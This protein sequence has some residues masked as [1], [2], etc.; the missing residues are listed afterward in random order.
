[1]ERQNVNSSSLKSI[2]YDL[3]LATLE[4]EF[5]N[6]SIYQYFDIPENIYDSLMSANSHGTYL[7][8]NIK[9]VFKYRR[10]N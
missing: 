1:M 6:N 10:I 3:D 9:G 5:L 2:G 4:I 7:A 8:E